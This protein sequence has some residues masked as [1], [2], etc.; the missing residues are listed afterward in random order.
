MSYLS[1]VSFA[2][3]K[4]LSSPFEPSYSTAFS[5]LSYLTS[6]QQEVSRLSGES[7]NTYHYYSS[8]LSTPTISRVDDKKENKYKPIPKVLFPLK[9]RKKQ[10]EEKKSSKYK[11]V[12]WNKNNKKWQAQVYLSKKL[13]KEDLD[14]RSWTLAKDKVSK[15]KYLGLYHTEEAAAEAY[16]LASLKIYGDTKRLNF[17]YKNYKKHF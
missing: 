1:P 17:P 7:Y 8:I 12:C 16:D 5:Y 11:G 6:S 10:E 3:H 9:R 13:A 14:S 2:T 15:Y 4:S